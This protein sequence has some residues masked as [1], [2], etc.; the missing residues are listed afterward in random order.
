MRALFVRHSFSDGRNCARF[1][2][3]QHEIAHCKFADVA[4]LKRSAKIFG[5]RRGGRPS[6][7]AFAKFGFALG[8]FAGL[9]S[10]FR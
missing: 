10:I 2:F 5:E 8:G 3:G 7:P 9:D 6:D 4:I 1:G